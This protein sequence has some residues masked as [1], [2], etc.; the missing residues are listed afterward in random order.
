MHKFER[1]ALLLVFLIRRWHILITVTR[2]SG[3]KFVNCDGK[4]VLSSGKS[5][6]SQNQLQFRYVF[7]HL[8]LRHIYPSE[9]ILHRL[10]EVPQILDRFSRKP[11]HN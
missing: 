9:F 1:L 10:H 3:M 11:I 8:S 2:K 4:C 5:Y 6:A 7:D